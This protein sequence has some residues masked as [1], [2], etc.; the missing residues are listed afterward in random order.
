MW[1]TAAPF[2]HHPGAVIWLLRHGE[3]ED[4]SRETRDALRKLTETGRRQAENA[5]KAMV[6]LGVELD[7]CLTSPRVRAAQTADLACRELGVE[8]EPVESLCGGKFDAVELAAG[9]GE[10]LLVAHSAPI[11]RATGGRVKLRKGGLAA[12]DDGRVRHL[13]T[14]GDVERL[15]RGGS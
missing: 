14:P 8:A 5:G 10:V 4:R 3:A 11:R 9:R 15:A 7:A 2:R 1:W 13:M 12:I 6:A